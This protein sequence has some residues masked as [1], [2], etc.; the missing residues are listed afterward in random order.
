MGIEA[1][2]IGFHRSH[3][4]FANSRQ[5]QI[6]NRPTIAVIVSDTHC[7]RLMRRGAR[8]GRPAS[9]AGGRMEPAGARPSNDSRKAP[10]LVASRQSSCPPPRHRR[11]R[12]P[13]DIRD[14]SGS[15]RWL[16]LTAARDA[17]LARVRSILSDLD[18]ASLATP[19][20]PGRPVLV[21][22]TRRCVPVRRIRRRARRNVRRMSVSR[23]L[24]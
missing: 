12:P 17:Y 19:S 16:A 18:D 24:T 15:T 14:G 9:S 8:I 21:A 4:N 7:K 5:M 13:A 11:F 10:L 20:Q 2:S 22:S 6:Y 3:R 1:R 23:A